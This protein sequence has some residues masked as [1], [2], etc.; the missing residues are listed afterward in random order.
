MVLSK[1]ER[2]I[3]VG[4]GAAIA[5]LLLDSFVY[6]PYSDRLD[7]IHTGEKNYAEQQMLGVDAM[8]QQHDRQ[9]EW[10]GMLNSGLKTDAAEADSQARH[11][12]MDWMQNTHVAL[13]TI[14]PE[15]QTAVGKFQVIGFHVT[16]TGSMPSITR[17]LWSLETATIPMRIG[18]VTIKPRKEGTDDLTVDLTISTLCMPPASQ[19]QQKSKDST[20]TPP[21]SSWTSPQ[22]RWEQQS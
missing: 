12:V 1:R 10:Q 2:Y 6:G 11:A 9:G 13:T 22:Q 20:S 15:R 8:K 5:I 4:V 14:T 17:L 18:D 19:T 21:V 16:G 3:G 7:Q